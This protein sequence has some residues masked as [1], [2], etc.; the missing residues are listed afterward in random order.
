MKKLRYVA[1]HEEIEDEGKDVEK[2]NPPGLVVNY[3]LVQLQIFVNDKL[4]L[5]NLSI[6]VAEERDNNVVKLG[7]TLENSNINRHNL[8]I[9]ILQA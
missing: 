4:N 1:N 9:V 2:K 8:K 7:G 3:D 5:E 6:T